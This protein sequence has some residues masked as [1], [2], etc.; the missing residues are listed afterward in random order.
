M[1]EGRPNNAQPLETHE[2]DRYDGY[3]KELNEQYR[4]VFERGC[5]AV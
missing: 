2:L 4:R 1:E 5:L 3:T